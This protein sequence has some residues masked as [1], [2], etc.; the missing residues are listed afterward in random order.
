MSMFNDGMY[1][2]RM[3]M[4]VEI[5]AYLRLIKDGEDGEPI[6]IDEERLQ[7]YID[8]LLESMT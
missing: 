2:A 4:K 3:D 6:T 7:G 5:I 1:E 8:Y